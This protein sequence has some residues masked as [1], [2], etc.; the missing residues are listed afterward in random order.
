MV[1]IRRQKTRTNKRIVTHRKRERSFDSFFCPHAHILFV[2]HLNWIFLCFVC[3]LLLFDILFAAASA[4]Y[5]HSYNGNSLRCKDLKSLT[6]LCF[7]AARDRIYAYWK[8]ICTK[9]VYSCR[10][11]FDICVGIGH[12]LIRAVSFFV[13]CLLLDVCTSFILK[14]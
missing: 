8:S 13:P 11:P 4:S 7:D 2:C 12:T 3:S 9:C 5:Q 10:A 1:L 6:L 14:R